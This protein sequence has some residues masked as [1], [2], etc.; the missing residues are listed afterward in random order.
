MDERT[1]LNHP[2]KTSGAGRTLAIGMIAVGILLIAGA[3]LLLV[4]H[5]GSAGALGPARIGAAFGNFTLTDLS[6]KPVQLSDYS[7]RPVLINAWATWCPPC[8]AE[9][10]DLNA[11]YQAHR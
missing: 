1:A 10:P 7:G 2:P 11:Y 3:V 6:G 5:Q 9:M 4:A 8:Q